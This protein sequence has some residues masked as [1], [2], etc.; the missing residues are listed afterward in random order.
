MLVCAADLGT[1]TAMQ[2][3]IMSSDRRTGALISLQGS[4]LLRISALYRPY[5]P[6]HSPVPVPSRLAAPA[7]GPSPQRTPRPRARG[8]PCRLCWL[9]GRPARASHI[10]PLAGARRPPRS[11]KHT[12]SRPACLAAYDQRARAH[13]PRPWLHQD[14]HV[15]ARVHF[16]WSRGQRPSPVLRAPAC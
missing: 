8:R 3:H 9:A 16:L 15:P 7:S 13:G 6:G 4:F 1:K 12:A 14:R 2:C 10:F 11:P 5:T